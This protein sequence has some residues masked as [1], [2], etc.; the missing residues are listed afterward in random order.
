M[1]P[2]ASGKVLKL[3]KLQ[4]SL[5]RVRHSD[6]REL[7]IMDV[8]IGYTPTPSILNKV[9][10]VVDVTRIQPHI[11]HL[12]IL[13]SIKHMGV[14]VMVAHSKE[15]HHNHIATGVGMAVVDA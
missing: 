14:M 7:H 12:A 13:L 6:L 5:D 10:V 3:R 15:E 9:L 11:S 4:E 2:L 8:A 1:F